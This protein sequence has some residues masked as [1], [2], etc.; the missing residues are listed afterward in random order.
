MNCKNCKQPCCKW[1][2]QANGTQRFFCRICKTT[3]Q[4]YY[5]YKAA[6]TNLRP[7]IIKLVCDAVSIRG[8]ARILSISITTVSKLIRCIAS[9]IV[10][11]SVPINRHAFEVEE[12][13]T[14]V[15][16]KQNQ[17][18][19]AYA[20]CPDTKQVIDFIVGKRTKA[21]LRTLINTVLQSGVGKI[22]TDGLSAYRSLIPDRM[23]ET[24]AY[25]I[26]HIERNNLNLRTH[27]KRLSRRTICFSKTTS[28]LEHCLKIY[29]WR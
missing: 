16:N 15:G 9:A 19:V 25:S 17:Y 7:M 13:R 14:F 8:M 2:R 18:W 22:R 28:M 10:K 26:N 21:S 24:S 4:E 20:F 3:Q 6:A 23:H 11:P 29:F 27:L 5:T 12:L 1:G